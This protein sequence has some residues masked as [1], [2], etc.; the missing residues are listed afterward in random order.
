MYDCVLLRSASQLACLYKVIH[1]CTLRTADLHEQVEQLVKLMKNYV[2]RRM[3]EDVEKGVP[4]KQVQVEVLM[5]NLCTLS[6]LI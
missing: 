5:L 3:K 1:C 4:P 2:L 6:L